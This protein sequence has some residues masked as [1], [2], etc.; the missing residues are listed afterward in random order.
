MAG[1]WD[2]EQGGTRQG[3]AQNIKELMRGQGGRIP[4]L[5]TIHLVLKRQGLPTEKGLNKTS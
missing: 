2:G 1:G 5:S 4:I 3:G